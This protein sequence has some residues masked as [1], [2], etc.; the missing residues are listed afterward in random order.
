MG[1]YISIEDFEDLGYERKQENRLKKN[2]LYNSMDDKSPREL[3]NIATS[4]YYGTYHEFNTERNASTADA[5]HFYK[6]AYEKLLK[7][8]KNLEL[9]YESEDYSR[10]TL[11]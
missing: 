7:Y 8:I 1:G 10:L 2:S 6:L 11:N 4:F 5:S 3:Y 9:R